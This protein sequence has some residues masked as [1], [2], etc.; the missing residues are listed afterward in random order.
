[1]NS[2]RDAARK[3]FPRGLRQP[4][5]GFRFSM[6]ALLVAAFASRKP[7]DLALDLGTGCGVVALA[8]LLARLRS[9]EKGHVRGVD[10][11]RE[12]VW[13]A[14]HNAALLGLQ[15]RFEARCLDLRERNADWREFV[16]PGAFDLVVANPPY[17][18]SGTGRTSPKQAK[19]DARFETQAD[20]QDFVLA[21]KAAC[22]TRGRL[23]LVQL[24]ERLQE[25]CAVLHQAGFG[26]KDILPLQSRSGE[27]ARLALLEA[28]N[29]GK[30]VLTL[31]PALVLYEGLGEKTRLSPEALAFCPFLACNAGSAGQ[32]SMQKPEASLE[33]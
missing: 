22:A 16:P 31:K 32:E 21:A 5:E 30:P 33:E 13:A 9:P 17:R 7:F 2:E 25:S 11:D 15:E 27:P 10:R 29:Q 18:K 4:H 28:R 20:I 19:T 23:V 8:M 3:F 26:V 6:D 14:A 1:M 24:A 12:M